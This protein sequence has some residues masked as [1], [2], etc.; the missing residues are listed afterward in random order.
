MGCGLT[1]GEAATEPLVVVLVPQVESVLVH[2]EAGVPAW[3]SEVEP[4]PAPGSVLVT[5]GCSTHES[6]VGVSPLAGGDAGTP[7]GTWVR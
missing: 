2:P 1:T 7:L 5:A 6:E 3:V 4:Q